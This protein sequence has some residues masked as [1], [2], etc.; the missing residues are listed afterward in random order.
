MIAAPLQRGLGLWE[1]DPDVARR[2]G[3]FLNRLVA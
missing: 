2:S 1:R 3:E